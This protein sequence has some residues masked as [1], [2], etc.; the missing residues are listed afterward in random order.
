MSYTLFTMQWKKKYCVPCHSLLF[1]K[2]TVL[3]L[4][5]VVCLWGLRL[6]GASAFRVQ[7]ASDRK[8]KNQRFT[9]KNQTA[10]RCLEETVRIITGPRG[11]RLSGGP[12]VVMICCRAGPPGV[13]VVSQESCSPAIVCVECVERE[14]RHILQVYAE[15]WRGGG[16]SRAPSSLSV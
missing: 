7:Q 4:P 5:D 16:K 6:I 14:Q 8:Q 10:G 15:L 13:S 11:D 3:E 2:L 1:N 9:C 12:G